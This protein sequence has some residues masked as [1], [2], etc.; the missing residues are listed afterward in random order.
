[1]LIKEEEQTQILVN[2]EQEQTMINLKLSSVEDN[3][4]MINLDDANDQTFEP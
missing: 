2:Q 3:Q 1:M 4:T